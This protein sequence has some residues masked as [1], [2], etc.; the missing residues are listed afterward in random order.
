LLARALCNRVFRWKR[1]R[2]SLPFKEWPRLPLIARIK[3]P[4]SI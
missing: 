3:R 2:R 1:E 4:A